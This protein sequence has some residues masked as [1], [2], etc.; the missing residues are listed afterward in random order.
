MIQSIR[1]AQLRK[2]LELGG[3]CNVDA[4]IGGAVRNH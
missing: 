1:T 3:D 4:D 2:Q